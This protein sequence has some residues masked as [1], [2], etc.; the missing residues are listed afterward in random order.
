LTETMP[1]KGKAGSTADI[2][3]GNFSFSAD[4]PPQGFTL[5]KVGDRLVKSS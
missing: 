2:Y 5:A 4:T 1:I 3:L